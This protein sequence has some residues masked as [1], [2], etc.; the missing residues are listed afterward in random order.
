MFYYSLIY[1]Y[2]YYCTNIYIVWDSSYEIN[3]R[4]LVILQKRII[5][6]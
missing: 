2:F 3:L 6:I 5:R 4:R 1:P